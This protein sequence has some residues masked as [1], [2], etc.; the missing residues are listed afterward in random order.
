MPPLAPGSTILPIFRLK[1]TAT[2]PSLPDGSPDFDEWT[3]RRQLSE[4]FEADPGDILLSISMTIL[5]RNG[6]VL[7]AVHEAANNLFN[8]SIQSVEPLSQSCGLLDINGSLADSNLTFGSDIYLMTANNTIIQTETEYIFLYVMSG[9]IP[10]L[11]AAFCFFRWRYRKRF[12]KMQKEAKETL[13][14]A[15]E[16]EAN[17]R[18]QVS[19]GISPSSR[20]ENSCWQLQ[21]H[22]NLCVCVRIISLSLCHVADTGKLPPTSKARHL[23]LQ[24]CALWHAPAP[25]LWRHG[26]SSN[27]SHGTHD[28]VRFGWR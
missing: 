27:Q 24:A 7:T 12:N 4:V 16:R 25:Q 18:N 6:R 15:L 5:A 22:P 19:A 26:R 14:Q 3:F 10:V 1:F 2:V 11:L 13:K 20:N 23:F 9:V 28:G 21:C 17:L 8:M